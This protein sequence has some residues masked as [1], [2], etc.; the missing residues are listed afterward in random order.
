MDKICST[1]LSYEYVSVTNLKDIAY[2]SLV[3]MYNLYYIDDF[4]AEINNEQLYI[5][6]WNHGN[7]YIIDFYKEL[8]R[9]LHINGFED[10][11]DD[12]LSQDDYDIQF[13]QSF[14]AQQ[15]RY[16]DYNDFINIEVL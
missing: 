7:T 2:N 8:E 12:Y 11:R 16:I 3:D 10:F 5:K 4:T 15:S 6:V 13:N 9:V 1:T 14:Y